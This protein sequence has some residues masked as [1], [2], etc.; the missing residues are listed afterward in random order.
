[1]NSTNEKIR[2]LMVHM[3]HDLD[4]ADAA[5]GHGLRHFDA[6]EQQALTPA[7][8]GWLM[9][10]SRRGEIPGRQREL[11]IHYASL[12]GGSPLDRAELEVLLDR[13]LFAPFP[14]GEEETPP[15]RLN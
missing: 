8:R 13:L 14:D 12:V 11:I 5:G 10:L 4:D 3:L 2:H 15:S 1:M 9:E 6:S 7:A